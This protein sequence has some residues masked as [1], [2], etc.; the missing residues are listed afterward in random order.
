MPADTKSAPLISS[1]TSGKDLD[2]VFETEGHARR[3]A[4]WRVPSAPSSWK[5]DIGEN[6]LEPRKSAW[7]I[8]WDPISKEN[9]MAGARWEKVPPQYHLSFMLLSIML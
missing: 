6:S 3:Q 1:N 2:Y 5:A 4:Q 8:Q 9:L 7:A